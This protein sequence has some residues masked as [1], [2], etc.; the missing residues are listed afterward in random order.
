MKLLLF[1]LV[2]VAGLASTAIVSVANQE[3]PVQFTTLR[4]E[5]DTKG[6][7][8]K[9]SVIA[10]QDEKAGVVS[11]SISAFGK[12]YGVTKEQL[13]G[14]SNVR[15]NGVRVIYDGGI[16]GQSVWVHLEMGYSSGI[17]HQVKIRVPSNGSV[18]IYRVDGKTAF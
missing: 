18:E 9:V 6:R 11:L 3:S 5:S 8:G 14:V 4:F 1:L 13:A 2:L 12:E 17:V 15:W 16:F 7:S 10:T